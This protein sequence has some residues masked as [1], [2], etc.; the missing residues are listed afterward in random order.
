MFFVSMCRRTKDVTILL[1][2]FHH[3]NSE[4]H[5]VN[6]KHLN[7][8]NAARTF[9][10]PFNAMRLKDGSSEENKRATFH[11]R[12]G[13]RCLVFPSRLEEARRGARVDRFTL[14]RSQ[15]ALFVV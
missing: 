5:S 8:F 9:V 13:Q 3:P 7:P 11:F 2:P 6:S 12:N 10:C 1:L 14:A 15:V 4:G